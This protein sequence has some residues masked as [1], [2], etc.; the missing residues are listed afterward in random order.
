MTPR[1]SADDRPSEGHDEEY[2]EHYGKGKKGTVKGTGGKGSPSS[3]CSKCGS[4]WH[5]RDD[6]P[7]SGDGPSWP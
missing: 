3:G 1:G 7:V 4:K 5:R 2:D 6:C